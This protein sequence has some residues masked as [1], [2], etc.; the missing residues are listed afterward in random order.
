MAES[1]LV[2]DLCKSS[3]FTCIKKPT[4][5]D[6][7]RGVCHRHLYSQNYQDYCI[8]VLDI[9]L[10]ITTSQTKSI[11]SVKAV[12]SQPY[13]HMYIS[14]LHPVRNIGVTIFVDIAGFSRLRHLNFFTSK[15][16]P[17]TGMCG[18]NFSNHLSLRARF[19]RQ[20][21]CLTTNQ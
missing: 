11:A 16:M 19:A 1:K 20:Q 17:Y 4:K 3:Y 12:Y 21:G 2:F 15:Y 14:V 9:F 7:I 10:A 5:S 18:G 13:Y 6:V 8:I